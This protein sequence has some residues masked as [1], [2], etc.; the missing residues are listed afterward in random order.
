MRKKGVTPRHCPPLVI[1]PLCKVQNRLTHKNMNPFGCEWTHSAATR[2][3][4]AGAEECMQP[5]HRRT[6]GKVKRYDAPPTAGGEMAHQQARQREGHDG[7]VHPESRGLG[8][9]RLWDGGLLVV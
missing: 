9:P 4:C 2:A 6:E 3:C 8:L 7:D 1:L 5:R